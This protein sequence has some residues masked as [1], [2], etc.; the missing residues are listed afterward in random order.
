M[1]EVHKSTARVFLLAGNCVLG[2][3]YFGYAL[4]YL[5]PSE[6]TMVRAFSLND[7]GSK[8]TIVGLVNGNRYKLEVAL[9][10]VG[11][12][13]GAFLCGPF[14]AKFSRRECLMITDFIGFVGCSLGEITNFY[15]LCLSRLTIGL[16]VGLNSTLVQNRLQ[17]KVP[18][19]IKEYT[20]LSLRG[21]A[22]AMNQITVNM[23]I[24]VSLIMGL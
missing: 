15:T 5:N 2:S 10:S 19:C 21:T 12:A 22:G 1:T 7:Y 20:P 24:F 14:L 18:M 17:S 4:G 8:D 3:F 11:A 6:D 9:M 13:V 23:G 16:A